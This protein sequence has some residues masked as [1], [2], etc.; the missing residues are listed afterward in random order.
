MSK[1]FLRIG[2]HLAVSMLLSVVSIAGKAQS[3]SITPN[4]TAAANQIVD[5]SGTHFTLNGSAWLP[6]GL[7]IRG[8]IAPT[9]YEQAQSDQDDYNAQINYGTT[10]L[11]AAKS[12]GA[13][14]LRLQVSQYYLDPQSPKYDAN[15]VT[16]VQNAITQARNAGFVVIISMQDE[17]RSGDPIRHPLPTDA[18]ERNW[19]QL[20]AVFGT[21]RGV[22]FELFNEPAPD[23]SDSAWQIWASGGTLPNQTEPSV[24]MQT[25]I[26]DLRNAGSLNVIFLDGLKSARTLLG[27][28]L[29]SDPLHRIAYAVHP[30]QFGSSD[31]SHWDGQFGTLSQTQP[32]IVTEWSAQA[33]N[34]IGLNN[35][36]SYQVAVDL[37][38]YLTAHSIPLSAGAFD[39]EGFMAQNVPGWTP[40]NYN[41]YSPSETL[42]DAGL[43]VNKLFLANYGVTLTTADG[44]TH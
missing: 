35:L 7:Q 38:N 42:D 40:T 43:L 25:L 21:D 30:Y 13:D 11:N 33:G 44:I 17:P 10:E 23:R 5:I 4:T 18:T 20:N 15:Y 34:P 16:T 36:S 22:I 3:S 19:L 28:P 12:F 1:P 9:S 39:V 8:F 37:L 41:N 6:K 26:T 14:E 32:V 27:V 2:S 31:E 29:L 24:G